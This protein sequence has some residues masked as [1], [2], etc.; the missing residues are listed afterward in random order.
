M[1][2][3]ASTVPGGTILEADVCIVGTGP[4]GFA[5][6]REFMKQTV[7]KVC[8]L[9][10]GGFGPTFKAQSLYA[11]EMAGLRYRPLDAVRLRMFGGS[12]H[13]WHA[14][15]QPLDAIDFEKRSWIPESGWPFDLDY[16]QPY[17]QRCEDFFRLPDGFDV[18]KWETSDWKRFP[19][20]EDRIDHKI[21]QLSPIPRLGVT[22]RNEM[23]KSE[24]VSTYLNANV[25]DILTAETPSAVSS[26]KVARLNGDG[27]FEVKAKT[28][29]LA[30]GG[31]ENPRLMLA[32]NR[33]HRDGIGNQHD[34]VGRFFM[35]HP[36]VDSGVLVPSEN[37]L[38]RLQFYLYRNQRGVQ[39]RST[40]ALSDELQRENELPNIEVR[41]HPSSTD[42]DSSGPASFR[43]LL[44]ELYMTR[45]GHP[46]SN[47]GVHVKEMLAD[48]V[49]MVSFAARKAAS[50]A[51]L[52]GVPRAYLLESRVEQVPNWNSR[53]TLSDKK[54][55]LGVRRIK[56][57]WRLTEEELLGARRTQKILAEEFESAGIGTVK[58]HL[59]ENE[60]VPEHLLQGTAHHI[61][62]TRISVDPKKGVVDPDCCVHGIE[63]LFV[64]GSS[65]FPTAGAVTPTYTIVALALRLADHLKGILAAS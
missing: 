25:V 32:A 36:I 1:I 64:A 50:I 55:H 41:L 13:R 6:A 24:N 14:G 8:V 65:V 9:E 2:A 53:V 63:N 21:L 26:V 54:D 33:T 60:A 11:G 45:W 37:A 16:L 34:L 47:V 62:T 39:A 48:P 20:G 58:T 10:G 4:A 5:L 51:R 19:I 56:L 42:A 23:A 31:L 22:Y 46:P 43:F 38:S 17:Y 40:I 49:R 3:D 7:L 52:T 28:F 12:S 61:G 27:G 59:G 30:A 29:V 35:S 57:D 15:C 44:K 18:E